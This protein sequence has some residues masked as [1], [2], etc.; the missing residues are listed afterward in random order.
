M[1]KNT[2]YKLLVLGRRICWRVIVYLIH[3]ITIV[4]EN[5]IL[6]CSN[7]VSQI[8]S[9]AIKVLTCSFEHDI[10]IKLSLRH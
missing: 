3:D 7:A 1:E 8:H 5:D 9:E 4:V 2:D 10:L 6:Q